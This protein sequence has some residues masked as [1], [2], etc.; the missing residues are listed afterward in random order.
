MINK[1]F[2]DFACCSDRA[3]A[4]G[5]SQFRHPCYPLILIMKKLGYAFFSFLILYFYTSSMAEAPGNI[6]FLGEYSNIVTYPNDDDAHQSG[7][8]VNLYRRHSGF[9]FGDFIYATGA[10]EGVRSQLIDLKVA[11]N[12]ISFT[13]RTSASEDV[14]GTLTKDLFKFSGV[15]QKKSIR[16]VLSKSDGKKHDS[17]VQLEKII[18]VRQ[19]L[20][21]MAPKNYEDYLK[22]VPQAAW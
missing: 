5:Q 22:F 7:Y 19:P 9:V 20:V 2:S 21:L 12:R 14:D 4:N 8:A 17:E 15:I 1:L 3:L 16:G 13:A 18:L 6:R 10:T 11:N